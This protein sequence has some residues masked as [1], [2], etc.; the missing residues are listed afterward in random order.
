MKRDYWEQMAD[1]YET[2]IFDV[3]KNDRKRIVPEKINQY[4]APNKTA[5]DI[6][7][8]IGKFLPQLSENFQTV[9][10]VDISPKC[11][12]KA[13]ARNRAL[14]NVHY[15]TVDLT[16]ARACLPEVDVALSVNSIISPSLTRRARMLDAVR[17]HLRSSGY[18]ILVVPSLES[19][20][21]ASARLIEWNMRSGISTEMAGRA[22]FQNREG[23]RNRRV[24]EGIIPIGD[25]PT[26]HYL[27]EELVVLLRNHGMEVQE[28]CKI[29][30]SWRTEFLRPPSWMKDPLPWDWICVAQKVA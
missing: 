24:H 20:L 25:V 19:A 3:S 23:C 12:A 17:K 5:S 21:F 6:G 28:T 9:I 27:K 1:N 22:S 30:Y 13:R 2:E 26:K 10:A 16:S 14:P 8:G 29:E 18:L 15:F 4:G 7:C 11:I